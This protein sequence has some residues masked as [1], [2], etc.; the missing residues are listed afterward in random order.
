[1]SQNVLQNLKIAIASDTVKQRSLLRKVMDQAGLDVV[2]SEPLTR[3][4]LRKLEKCG[5]Q[6][7][8][9]DLHDEVEHDE[10]LVNELLDS[11]EIP[12][13]F[14]DVTALT[15]NE[16]EVPAKWYFSL[17]SKI[18]ALAGH[19]DWNAD[20]MEPEPV[21][22][23]RA[24]EEFAFYS[25]HA[26]VARN[27]W[28]LGASLGGPEAVKRFL[29][30]LPED[31]PAAF[32]L[33]QH[34]G[35]NFVNLLAEQLDRSTALEV[36]TPQDGHVFRHQQVLVSPVNQ[37]IWIN[38]IGTVELENIDDETPYTPSINRVVSDAAQR[39]GEHAG[40]IIFSGMGDDGALGCY[41]MHNLG[42][43]VWTQSPETC[44][45]SS[46][47]DHVRHTCGAQYTGTPEQLAHNL[48]TFLQVRSKEVV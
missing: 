19:D 39:Y 11:V 9:L 15:L 45:V 4:F 23:T 27:V 46:M 26:T 8:L 17:M 36:M 18:A 28:V 20:L 38:A 5:A 2:L 34:L 29:T 3:L 44:V 12:I 40:A 48:I 43:Q 13:V 16:P 6:V 1:M 41:E 31:L 10:T 47:P 7:L 35:A 30:E 33:A 14:N 37:R 22:I 42:G 25:E 32:I 24:E 21:Y